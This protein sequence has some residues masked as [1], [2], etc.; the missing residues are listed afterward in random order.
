MM[1]KSPFEYNRSAA[2]DMRDIEKA[3][4]GGATVR[5]VTFLSPVAGHISAS[6]VTPPPDAPAPPHA[7][8][9]WVHWFEPKAHDS[10]RTQ[11]L[12]EAIEM[13][14]CG[15]VSILPD[16]FWTMTP[17]GWAMTASYPWRTEFEH[18][19]SLIVQQVIDLRRTLDVLLAQ[20]GVDPERLGFVGHDFGAMCGALVAGV[21]KRV[22][23]YVLMA[24]TYTFGDWFLY[25][26]DRSKEAEQR[27]V[28]RIA[29]FDPAT[30]VAH[31]APAVLYF[32]FADADGYVPERAAERFFDAASSP[33]EIVWYE[34]R[35]DLHDAK[36]DTQRDR[37]VWLRQELSLEAG[38]APG[39]QP[40]PEDDARN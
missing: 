34:A 28:E 18:D 8:V 30:Y 10:N 6:I 16:C 15:V 12:D 37:L 1:D 4:R 26:S 17:R 32:Q 21:D 35:H 40:S 27:Y 33:K 3:Q 20:P 11:F 5:E 22:K 39:S 13:A 19:R 14:R 24:G 31:A 2:L 7:G 38:A 36:N 23:V 9:L 25:G 29:Q